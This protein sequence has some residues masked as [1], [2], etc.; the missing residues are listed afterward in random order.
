MRSWFRSAEDA[1]WAV[2][3]GFA[4]IASGLVAALNDWADDNDV[5]PLFH[6][7][8]PAFDRG[9]SLVL[10]LAVALAWVG[11]VLWRKVHTA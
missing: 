1:R 8:R 6:V 9:L 11:R 3:W 10:P 2:T 5:A 4:S 7:L